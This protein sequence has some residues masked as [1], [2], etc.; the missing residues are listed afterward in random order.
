MNGFGRL[1]IGDRRSWIISL[2]AGIVLAMVACLSAPEFAAAAA[3]LDSGNPPANS[4]LL[5]T[6]ERA[7]L[8]FTEPLNHSSQTSAALYDQSGQVISGPTVRV[9]DARWPGTVGGNDGLAGGAVARSGNSGPEPLSAGDWWRAAAGWDRGAFARYRYAMT[10]PIPATAASIE[11]GQQAFQAN[12]VQGHGVTGRGDGP[13]AASLDPPP[14]DFT[15]AHSSAHLDG[16][17]FT[18]IKFGK[19]P[20]AMPAFGDNLSDE[21]IWDLVNYVRALQRPPGTPAAGS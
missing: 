9:D 20:T 1:L 13:V 4:V 10:N 11:R 15:A 3:S 5:D 16:E 12:C 19:P 7:T 21:E 6:P 18:W 2:L 14:A 8:R 17:F